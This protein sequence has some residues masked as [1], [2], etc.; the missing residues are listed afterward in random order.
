[1]A[2]YVCVCVCVLCAA[3]T[4]PWNRASAAVCPLDCFSCL[5]QHILLYSCFRTSPLYRL[6]YREKHTMSQRTCQDDLHVRKFVIG[7]IL[8]QNEG[9]L[10]RTVT[11]TANVVNTWRTRQAFIRAH[12]CTQ[13]EQLTMHH[14]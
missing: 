10:G 8:W 4:S 14:L 13:A 11:A 2:V 7:G 3:H 9:S 5:H 6:F 12:T 1:M